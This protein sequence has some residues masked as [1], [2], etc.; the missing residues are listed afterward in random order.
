MPHPQFPQERD[1]TYLNHAG[2]GAW[3]QH[4]ADAVAAFAAENARR[5]AAGYM[6][7]LE[8]ERRLRQRCATL[9]GAAASE[10]VALVKN[11]SE[12]LSF[13]AEGLAWEPGDEVVINRREFPSNRIPWEA[14]QD[15]GVVV[16]D[17]YLDPMD[18]EAALIDALGPRTR[19]LTVSAVQYG[20]G[21]RMD[22]PRLAA[23]CKAN[24]TL[25]CVDAIQQL[26]ALRFDLADVDADF[27]VA[28]GH[29]WMLGPEGL[30]LFYCRPSLR[31]ALRLTQYGWHMVRDAGNYETKEW[32]PAQS[33]QRFECGSPNLLAIH[34][35]EASLAVLQDEVGMATVESGVLDNTRHLLAR[36]AASSTLETISDTRAERLSG[37]VTFRAPGAD[38]KALYRALRSEGVMCA[39]RGGGVRL[40]PHFYID[41]EQLDYA[42]ERAEALVGACPQAG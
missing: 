34:G 3:P 33:A 4:A 32:E 16:R 7:W 14:L 8:T 10:D 42:I 21:L 17:P 31:P 27:V 29:K 25:F 6:R 2:V 36:I 41:R 24:G 19:L 11:T 28:D 30:G 23:A 37:I 18:P 13:I 26:G 9:I 22:L 15:R 12:A 5:G 1:I 40:S 38:N 35:L 20:D 39:A